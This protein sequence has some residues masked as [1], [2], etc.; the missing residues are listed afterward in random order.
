M[1]SPREQGV[2]LYT[3]HIVTN[4]VFEGHGEIMLRQAGC[5]GQGVLRSQ[6]LES[7]SKSHHGN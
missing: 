7:G 5:K 1:Q 2:D 4:H 3:Y 6:L